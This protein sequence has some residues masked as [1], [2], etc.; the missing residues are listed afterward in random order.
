M[1]ARDPVLVLEEAIKK[2]QRVGMALVVLL[3]E[4]D[5][6]ALL[7]KIETLQQVHDNFVACAAG[8]PNG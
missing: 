7:Q 8:C 6:K 2:S 3:D 1:V 5:A 4:D